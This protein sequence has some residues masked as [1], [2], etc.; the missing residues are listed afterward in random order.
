MEDFNGQ[1]VQQ[2][3]R[4]DIYEDSNQHGS[5]VDMDEETRSSS[6]EGASISGPRP[7]PFNGSNDSTSSEEDENMRNIIADECTVDHYEDIRSHSFEDVA[8][9]D[10]GADEEFNQPS[11]SSVDMDEEMRSSSREGTSAT[12]PLSAPSND[13]IDPTNIDDDEEIESC[14][15][16]KNN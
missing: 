8:I 5:L 15:V 6:E 2:R 14:E 13:S 12:D 11:L 7:V 9:I 16:E 4:N 3:K 10:F 1:N